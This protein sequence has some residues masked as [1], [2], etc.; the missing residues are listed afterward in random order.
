MWFPRQVQIS[1]N[2]LKFEMTT[3]VKENPLSVNPPSVHNCVAVLTAM[4]T[5]IVHVYLQRKSRTAL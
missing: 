3:T 5:E 4:K 2:Q 1:V